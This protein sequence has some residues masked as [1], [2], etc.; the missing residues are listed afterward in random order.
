MAAGVSL[1]PRIIDCQ[2]Q[3]GKNVATFGYAGNPWRI[4]HRGAVCRRPRPCRAAKVANAG[5]WHPLPTR[6]RGAQC[7]DV[8][9]CDSPKLSEAKGSG[10]NTSLFRERDLTGI[11]RC[12]ILLTM[13]KGRARSRRTMTELLREA[14]AEAPSLRAIERATGVKRQS[15]MKFVR[16]EQSLRLDKADALAAYFGIQVKK[17]R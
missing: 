9:C 11:A 5:E 16:R 12:V 3:G 17:G 13:Q 8:L 1:N 6:L 15:M 10:E 2:T 4:R 7:A 14:L